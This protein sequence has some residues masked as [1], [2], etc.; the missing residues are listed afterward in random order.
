MLSPQS[1]EY[2]LQYLHTASDGTLQEKIGNLAH[3][4]AYMD[5]SAE[6]LTEVVKQ[7]KDDPFGLYV[8][9]LVLTCSLVS[10]LSKEEIRETI[11]R[12]KNPYFAKR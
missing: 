3:L 7:E 11:E 8:E 4:A 10:E 2:S 9:R 12:S 1:G 6:D 5:K